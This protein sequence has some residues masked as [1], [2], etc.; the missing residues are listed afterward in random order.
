MPIIEMHLLQGRTVEQKHRVAKA[1]TEAVVQSL[2]V[3]AESVRI[4][5]TEHDANG[6]YVAGQTSAQRA[7]LLAT[8]EAH[9]LK[10]EQQ[11]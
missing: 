11:A 5:I 9:S 1:I 3:K 2:D 8:A 10:E 7:A 6:F 4:L